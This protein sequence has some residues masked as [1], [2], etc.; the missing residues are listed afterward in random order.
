MFLI[1]TINTS[2]TLPSRKYS[3]NLLDI[4]I[5]NI[6]QK[7]HQY[8]GAALQVAEAGVSAVANTALPLAHPLL[9]H[10]GGWGALDQWAC[11]GLD[12]VEEVVPIITQPTKEVRS[13]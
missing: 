4:I 10:V 8:V 5:T 1:Y 13:G 6:L 9:N 7:E 2:R 12:R 3:W 11:Q